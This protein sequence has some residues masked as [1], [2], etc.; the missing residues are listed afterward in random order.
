MVAGSLS[1]RC[2]FADEPVLLPAGQQIDQVDFE[3]HVAPLISRLGCNA[4]SCHGASEGKGG[5][6]LSLFGHD[7]LMDYEAITDSES[8]R[9]ERDEPTSSLILEK[10]SLAIEHEGGLRLPDDSWEYQLISKW[11]QQGAKHS[12]GSGQLRSVSFGPSELILDESQSKQTFR[13]WATYAD[14]SRMDVTALAQLRTNDEAVVTIQ[15][16][17]AHRVAAGDTSLVATYGGRPAS[18]PVLVPNTKHADETAFLAT[19]DSTNPDNNIINSIIDYNNIVDRFISAKLSRLRI[20]PSGRC[21]D[22]TF[23]RRLSLSVTGQ[24]PTATASQQFVADPNPHKRDQKIDELLRSP[25]NSAMW[26]TR[27]CEITGSR[28]LGQNPRDVNPDSTIEEDWHTWFRVRFANNVPYNQIARDVLCSTSQGERDITTFI[29]DNIQLAAGNQTSTDHYSSGQPLDLF[30]QRPKV[31]EEIDL[32]GTAERI[33]SAFLGIRIE[34]ARCH[35]HPFDRWSQLDHRSFA[36]VFS[37]VRFGLSP[38]LRGGLVDALEAQRQKARDGQ[39]TERIPKM[40]EVYL[41][42]VNRDLRHPSSKK[43]L[44]AKPLNGNVLSPAVDRRVEF[45][46]WLTSQSN[47]YFARNI[48]NRVWARYFGIGIVEPIDAFSA[49]NPPS[50]PKLLD[51]LARDFIEHGFDIRR[52]ERQILRSEAWQ[53]STAAT[54]TNRGDVRN[55]ARSHVRVLPAEVIVDALAGAIGDQKQRAVEFTKQR[56]GN[57][58]LDTY[59]DVFNRPK[60][61]LTCDCEQNNEPTLRQSMLLLADPNLMT[62][63]EQGHVAW[64][65]ASAA[66]DNEVVDDLFLRTLSRLPNELERQAARKYI[67]STNKRHRA[68]ADLMWSLINTREFATNH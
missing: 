18:V 44:P 33:S 11:I 52:L 49:G 41:S 32:E 56:S 1:W 21:S 34:C 58:L 13:V 68:L 63:I 31:N 19:V 5:F 16:G 43:R 28:D 40:R 53:R 38:G 24:L 14:G 64:L 50:H 17:E 4:G 62:R 8:G 27:M 65:A 54:E 2:G 35:K 55:Y 47:P 60:R 26:A 3:R 51:A 46:D 66:T 23:L 67:Q 20:Q 36:N 12:L 6:R 45:V 48:V 59:F 57:E 61:E 30:W 39:P 7:L 15:I 37:Q 22:E 9:V 25:L 10:P 42:T 29:R